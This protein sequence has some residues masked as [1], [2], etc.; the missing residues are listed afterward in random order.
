MYQHNRGPMIRQEVS[1]KSPLPHPIYPDLS[2]HMSYH[3]APSTCN[4]SPP[5]SS[6]LPAPFSTFQAPTSFKI[7]LVSHPCTFLGGPLGDG[8]FPYASLAILSLQNWHR[9]LLKPGVSP[10]WD[11]EFLVDKNP[12]LLTFTFLS[13]ATVPCTS[14]LN[15]SLTAQWVNECSQLRA[16]KL[17]SR[18]FYVSQIKRP[19]ELLFKEQNH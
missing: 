3:L 5:P 9:C 1:L 18:F 19:L 12:V 13:L 14:V 11:S 7:Q 6:P 15:K 8:S 4:T 17:I 2:F 16:A 10:P